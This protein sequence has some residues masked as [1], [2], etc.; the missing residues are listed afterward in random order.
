M[1]DTTMRELP[2][3]A[4]LFNAEALQAQ[5]TTDDALREASSIDGAVSRI[6][7]QLSATDAPSVRACDNAA[8]L[9]AK[10][11]T[12]RDLGLDLNS[13]QQR[14]EA[15]ALV[16]SRCAAAVAKHQRVIANG[17]ADI[18]TRAAEVRK[19]RHSI[20]TEAER[21]V[22]QRAEVAAHRRSLE[23]AVA[24]AVRSGNTASIDAAVSRRV[25]QETQLVAAEVRLSATESVLQE[26]RAELERS[27][28]A[29]ESKR[30]EVVA[31]AH[32]IAHV[33]LEEATAR[34]DLLVGFVVLAAADL[35]RRSNAAGQQRPRAIE[36]MTL[37]FVNADQCLAAR[38]AAFEGFSEG[39]TQR[40]AD[41]ISSDSD[42]DLLAAAR[43]IVVGLESSIVD[44]AH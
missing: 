18:A 5:A 6:R 41:L 43:A 16:S 17:R 21:V 31:Q 33:Q 8:A 39:A 12:R 28:A 27:E 1:K 24:D 14:V 10:V 37:R 29:L 25:T 11:N 40:L 23:E 9:I 42:G 44:K 2:A 34:Y 15:F 30:A 38:L 13:V 4:L 36:A 32:A 35:M 26:R 7:R 3:A 19:E 22:R 20:D